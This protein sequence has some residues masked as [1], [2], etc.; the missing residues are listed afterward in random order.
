M[1][2]EDDNTTDGPA[3]RQRITGFPYENMAF[4]KTALR[5]DFRC[6]R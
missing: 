1:Q 3:K 6:G 4:K 2:T 5:F